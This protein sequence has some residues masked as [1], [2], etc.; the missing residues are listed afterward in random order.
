MN[1]SYKPSFCNRRVRVATK[2]TANTRNKTIASTFCHGVFFASLISDRTTYCN[3]Q[4]N[5]N[6][7]YKR[8]QFECELNV[9][10]D[11]LPKYM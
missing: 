1:A 5:I 2:A 4:K 10:N 6:L 9:H 8:F 3:P 7:F 11:T